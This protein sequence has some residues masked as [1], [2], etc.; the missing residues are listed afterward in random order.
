MG[1]GDGLCGWNCYHEYYAFVPGLSERNWTDGWLKEQNQ[2]EDT[3]KIFKGKEYT[4]YQATQK[5]RQMETAMRAQRQKVKLLQAGDADPDDVMLA[6]CKYQAQLDEYST[7]SKKMGLPQQRERIY[8]DGFGR[9][10]P[11]DKTAIKKYTKEMFDNATRDS[12]QYERYKKIIGDSVGTLADF[13]QMK[14]NIHKKFEILKKKVITYSEIDKKPWTEEFKQK[15]KEAYDRFERKG[16]YLSSHA[17][18]R[19]PRLNKKGFWE[20]T[21]DDVMSVLKSKPNYK[22]NE[23]RCVYF[24]YELQLAIVKNSETDDIV[25]IIRRKNPKEE[26]DNV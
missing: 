25:S 1:T 13:R 26:W 16:I 19:M 6:K 24:S 23:N 15:S 22:E 17:A 18:S 3:P 12:K 7:F 10:A 14:Y 9:V 21:E 2:K 4:G 20:I 8:M 5:Q 11:T